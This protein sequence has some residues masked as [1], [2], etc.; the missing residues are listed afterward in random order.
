[1]CHL[2]KRWLKGTLACVILASGFGSLIQN[3]PIILAQE[4]ESSNEQGESET[5][6]QTNLYTP[7]EAQAYIQSNNLVEAMKHEL[8]TQQ[9]LSQS[10]IDR[11]PSEAIYQALYYQLTIAPGEATVPGTFHVIASQ[12]PEIVNGP[13]QQMTAEEAQKFIQENN[14][15]ETTKQLMLE[16]QLLTQEQLD[17]LPED[18][19]LNALIQQ[20]TEHD[21]AGDFGNTFQILKAMYPEIFEPE[22]VE[23]VVVPNHTQQLDRNQIIQLGERQYTLEQVYLL[24]PGEAG[25]TSN[26]YWVGIE[27]EYTNETDQVDKDYYK[28]WITQVLLVQDSE[29][30]YNALTMQQY[31]LPKIDR[32]VRLENNESAER[33]TSITKKEVKPKETVRE[34]IY[35]RL[36]NIEDDIAIYVAPQD[37]Q[38]ELEMEGLRQLPPRSAVYYS[39][40]N[41]QI[42]YLFDFDQLYLVY[43]DQTRLSDINQIPG[44]S[45]SVQEQALSDEAWVQYQKLVQE[46]DIQNSQIMLLDEVVYE[47][48]GDMVGVRQRPNDDEAA[49]PEGESTE[50]ESEEELDG[51][52]NILL[53]FRLN[54]ERQELVNE[55]REMY[56]LLPVD[57]KHLDIE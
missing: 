47:L 42:A 13:D 14:L 46:L 28:E 4:E 9:Y 10:K 54:K 35:Y 26:D 22:V 34:I 48:S 27:V 43:S 50:G 25:N 23:T 49:S 21:P 52:S 53:T 19:V 6:G 55:Y 45:T 32:S 20:F 38:Y 3:Y 36:N 16:A 29:R 51:L 5:E 12:Y 44:R 15:V 18:A 37:T 41:N 56:K 30:G 8:V 17:Q 39:S 40:S 57:W 31:K 1:M 24:A 7:E 2:L 11:L 33:T